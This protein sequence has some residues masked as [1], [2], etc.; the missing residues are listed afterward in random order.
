M[1]NT[2]DFT[3]TETTDNKDIAVIGLQDNRL[4]VYLVDIGE[5]YEGDYDPED[6]DD[7]ELLRIDAYPLKE[8]GTIDDDRTFS[9][10]TSIKKDSTPLIQRKA[11]HHIY[12]A[13]RQFMK[14]NPGSSLKA[15]MEDLSYLSDED[16]SAGGKFENEKV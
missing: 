5:G 15:V 12:W 14:D 2:Y 4:M 11:I 13:I 7:A 3:P 1:S 10:C 6:P 16:F 8:D 9:V